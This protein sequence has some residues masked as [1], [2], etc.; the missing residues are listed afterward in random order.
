M[1][2]VMREGGA[3]DDREIE[4]REVEGREL[5]RVGKD[6][7]AEVARVVPVDPSVRHDLE[8]A[9]F[10]IGL[11]WRVQRRDDDRVG[12]RACEVEHDALGTA[13]LSQEVMDQRHAHGGIFPLGR[14]LGVTLR[15]ICC[16]TRVGCASGIYTGC[17][18]CWWPAQAA[19]W[20]SCGCFARG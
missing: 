2:N 4:V 17:D 20:K 19:T 6:V 11:L 1:P 14:L 18:R 13:A 12:Q 5:F 9:E 15:S 8:R 16:G 7:A 3:R 10:G